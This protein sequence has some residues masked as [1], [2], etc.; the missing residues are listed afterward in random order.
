MGEKRTRIVEGKVE[1]TMLELYRNKR[2]LPK[3]GIANWFEFNGQFFIIAKVKIHT[4]NIIVY[5]DYK[6]S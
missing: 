4:D 2:R 5:K 6:N 1:E 3:W